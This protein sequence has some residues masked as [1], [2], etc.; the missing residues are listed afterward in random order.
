[1]LSMLTVKVS[2]KHQI[3]VPATVRRQ[4][5]IRPGDRLGVEID[6]TRIVLQ[7][8]PRGV[9]EE[10]ISLAPELWQGIEATDY[11]RDLRHEWS[12]R[13]FGGAR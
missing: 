1:M 5:G 7:L 13:E 8:R 9:L 4:L 11:L 12:N 2:R 6:G 3:A 10:L